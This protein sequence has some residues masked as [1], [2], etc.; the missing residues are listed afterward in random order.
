M[1]MGFGSWTNEAESNKRH[2]PSR[3]GKGSGEVR[4]CRFSS[5]KAGFNPHGPT[6]ETQSGSKKFVGNAVSFEAADSVI[7]FHIQL[8]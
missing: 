5:K 3:N 7:P 1:V 8:I 6:L 4:R 2:T